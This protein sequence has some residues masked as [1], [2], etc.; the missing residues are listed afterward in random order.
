MSNNV[1]E[2]GEELIH[3]VGLIIRIPIRLAQEIEF[4]D[5]LLDY[6]VITETVA[7]DVLMQL[8]ALLEQELGIVSERRVVVVPKLIVGD[9]I[10]VDKNER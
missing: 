2:V 5:N 6:K 8:H 1:A 7:G 10:E 3:E 4:G 9:F